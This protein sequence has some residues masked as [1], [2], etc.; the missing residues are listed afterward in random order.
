MEW[1]YLKDG[2]QLG[3][4]SADEITQKKASGELQGTDLVW[5]EGMPDWLAIDTVPEFQSAAVAPQTQ[6]ASPAL[7][8]GGSPA[9]GGALGGQPAAGG[10]QAPIQSYLW[11]SI[12]VTLLCCMPFGIVGI[13]NAA[14][15]EG[16]VKKGDIAGAQTASEAAKKWTKIG[17]IV[18]LVVQLLYVGLVIIVG[19]ADSGSY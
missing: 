16:L 1:Y 2:Q 5:K 6:A 12:V 17:F 4:I 14:K 3:P 13:V 15:V 10:Y 7:G 9:L 8:G 11:Q 18:G 19:I